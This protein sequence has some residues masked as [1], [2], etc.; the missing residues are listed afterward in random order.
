M[1]LATVW[2]GVSI[3]LTWHLIKW[4]LLYCKKWIAVKMAFF[5][6]PFFCLSSTP[7]SV[8]TMSS[9][10]LGHF[11][12]L[13]PAFCHWRRGG[14]KMA[15]S[16][17]ETKWFSCEVEHWEWKAFKCFWA[18]Y[19]PSKLAGLMYTLVLNCSQIRHVRLYCGSSI[20]KQCPFQSFVHS[21]S[22]FIT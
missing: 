8:S 6:T 18:R 10:S 20:S 9:P 14:K 2:V 3:Y 13:V 17:T 5:N 21:T 19:W 11:P 15:R 22:H 1:S 7:T 4:T 16:V 12:Q